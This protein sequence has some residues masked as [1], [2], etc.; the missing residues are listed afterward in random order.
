MW[1][2]CQSANS[3][4]QESNSARSTLLPSVNEQL[5]KTQKT[6]NFDSELSLEGNSEL[7]KKS[8]L[9]HSGSLNNLPVYILLARFKSYFVPGKK[10]NNVSSNRLL[11]LYL[12]FTD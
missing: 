3:G 6:P 1:S 4:R 7:S 2:G 8:P 9:P 5:Q 11:L 12:Y 10:K